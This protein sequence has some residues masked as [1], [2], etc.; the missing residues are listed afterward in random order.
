MRYAHDFVDFII[1]KEL[2]QPDSIER[3][4]LI[5]CKYNKEIIR[6]SLSD[7]FVRLGMHRLGYDMNNSGLQAL[8]AI[9]A[10]LN[11]MGYSRPDIMIMAYCAQFYNWHR[12]KL[13]DVKKWPKRVTSTN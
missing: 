8:K 13:G 7:D 5:E 12:I 11:S 10:N 4:Y 9:Q 1:M 2:K 3:N 6:P